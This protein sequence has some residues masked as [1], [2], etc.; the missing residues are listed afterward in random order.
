MTHIFANDKSG[1]SVF[2][3]MEVDILKHDLQMINE[4]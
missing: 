2:C 3:I 1:L 4:G